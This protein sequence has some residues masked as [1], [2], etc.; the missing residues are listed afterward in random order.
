MLNTQTAARPHVIEEDCTM[1]ETTMEA[2][3]LDSAQ[4]DPPE[5][6]TQENAVARRSDADHV[7][8]RKSRRRLS[9][10]VS[11]R[12]LVVGVVMLAMI[13]GLITVGWLYLQTRQQLGAQERQA[14]NNAHAEKVAL[15]YAVRAAAMN[16]QNLN[17]WKTALVA[18]TSPEL[19]DKLT[20]AATSMEQILVPLQWTSTAQPLV[21]KVRSDNGGSYVVDCFVSVQTKTIQAPEPLQSTATYSVVVDSNKDWRIT[22]VGGVGAVVGQR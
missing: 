19:S 6:A 21:A 20:K 12:G 16:F 14:Q 11:A 7:A 22:D 17:E 8:D 4:D 9:L 18:G 3:E 10:T 15:D 5:R 13:G 2:P 1:S